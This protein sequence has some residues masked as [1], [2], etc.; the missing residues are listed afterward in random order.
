VVALAEFK[1]STIQRTTGATTVRAQFFEGDFQ[2]EVFV[3]TGRYG[4]ATIT[5]GPAATEEEIDLAI[6]A[7]ADETTVLDLIP[8]QAALLDG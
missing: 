3:R 4:T 5:L 6:A 2:G 8:D 7:K 1:H